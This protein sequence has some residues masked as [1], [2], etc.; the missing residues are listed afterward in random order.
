MSQEVVENVPAAVPGVAPT[1]M[2]MK[3]QPVK[4]K[5]PNFDPDRFIM[6]AKAI[7]VQNYNEHR[8]Q[9]Q[10]E[11]DMDSVY[12]VSF[13][14]VLGNWKAVVASPL[15]RGLLWEISYNGHRNE[16][17]LDFYKKITNVIIPLGEQNT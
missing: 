7:V 8:R 16:A 9:E 10:V 12:I 3:N 6:T 14:K 11:F 1:P 17:Y 4:E 2:K 15:A 5:K 13:G